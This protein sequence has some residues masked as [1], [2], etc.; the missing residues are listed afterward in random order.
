M[1]VICHHETA[2]RADS[3]SLL[4]GPILLLEGHHFRPF[5]KEMALCLHLPQ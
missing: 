2:L 1:E 5:D 3:A 4:N